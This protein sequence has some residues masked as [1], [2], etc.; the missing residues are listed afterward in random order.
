MRVLIGSGIAALLVW[1][2]ASG[3]ISVN[4]KANIE[5]AGDDG[6]ARHARVAGG[7]EIS[8]S[9]EWAG[10]APDGKGSR[11]DASGGDCAGPAVEESR[12][13]ISLP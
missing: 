4:V 8:L 1:G 5:R 12:I 3:A 6:C 7:T 2:I 10:R 13:E 11:R 9:V